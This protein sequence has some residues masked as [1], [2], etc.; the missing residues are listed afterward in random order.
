MKWNEK[1]DKYKLESA[2][3]RKTT[4]KETYKLHN[5]SKQTKL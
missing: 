2:V 3:E 5:V 4:N 1:E